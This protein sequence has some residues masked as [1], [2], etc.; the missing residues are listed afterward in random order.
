[1][2]TIHRPLARAIRAALAVF[3][4]S[5]NVA[6]A[7]PALVDAGSL[8]GRNGLR[9]DGVAAADRTGRV[10]SRAGDLNNDGIEDML[11]AAVLADSN[12]VDAGTAYVVFGR[13]GPYPP[14]LT[15]S[16][17]DGTRGFRIT[18]GGAGDQFGLAAAPAG[19]LNGDSID[20]LVIGAPY[21]DTNDAG[22]AY[23]IFGRSGGFP[24][25]LSVTTL[26]GNNGFRLTAAQAGNSVGFGVSGVGDF[27][28][29]GRDDLAV[30]AP[31][32][33]VSGLS[34]AGAAFV[35]YGRNAFPASLDLGSL[36]S[37]TGLRIVGEASGDFAGQRVTGGDFNG[38]G[39]VDLV[40]GAPGRN[41]VEENVGSAYVL[42]GR[43][44]PLPAILS[45][46]SFDGSNGFR[47]DGLQAEDI[48]GYAVTMVDING[49]GMD[50]VIVA[51]PYFDFE[52]RPDAGG[53]YVLF[54]SSAVQ[55]ATRS[56]ASISGPA[57][58]R[59][60]GEAL[61]NSSVQVEAAGD[62][63]ADG[64]ADL[65][66]ND[67]LAG[68]KGRGGGHVIFG[69]SQFSSTFRVADLD[70]DTGFTIAGVESGEYAG[71]SI[72]GG[73]FN[74]D[75]VSDV[76]VGSPRR[77]VNSINSGVA[78]LVFG[79]ELFADGFESTIGTGSN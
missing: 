44:G 7:R 67:F 17:L 66:L 42:Y 78:Y 24:A 70:G 74:G 36:D 35:V 16:S 27:N 13:S 60:E 34:N 71:I 53:A 73:D 45:V 22:A 61:S 50:D 41:L 26:D 47:L 77:S 38:D 10:V 33:D 75:A 3:V 65:V 18:G 19:D 49:D 4:F 25:S 56:L 6:F 21:A 72:T 28:G 40:I 2:S 62:V 43:P 79:T 11:I 69:R 12:G 68:G 39:R 54:G 31:N 14:S 52:E 55:P 32:F 30:G 57:G 76:L 29:D 58:F 63:N 5:A 8:N 20:D 46:S 1:M 23:V 64:F 59:F 15:L 37:S 51:S 48:A 9:L